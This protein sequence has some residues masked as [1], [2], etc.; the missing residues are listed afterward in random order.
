MDELP[1]DP[2]MLLSW[3]NLKLRNQYPSP[4]ELCKAFDIDRA[5][6]EQPLHDAGFEYLPEVNQYR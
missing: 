2:F 6:L 1:K 3:V 5:A 4:D